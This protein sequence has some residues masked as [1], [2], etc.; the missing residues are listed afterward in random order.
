M[1]NLMIVFLM[2]ISFASVEAQTTF[3]STQM[4]TMTN[5]KN[6][7]ENINSKIV[8]NSDTTEI[9]LFL[10]V[11]HSKEKI[12]SLLT[13]FNEKTYDVLVYEK[14]NNEILILHVKNGNIY[15]VVFQTDMDNTL[16]FN[17]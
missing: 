5:G 16:T 1:R 11:A 14:E 7:T 12:L 8:I 13:V 6:E 15:S 3:E 2:M 10:G 4:I 17:L 9:E